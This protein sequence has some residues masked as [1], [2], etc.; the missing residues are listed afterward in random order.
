MKA[1]EPT[2]Y[3]LRFVPAAIA[4]GALAFLLVPARGHAQQALQQV[5]WTAALPLDADGAN[6]LDKL[7]AGAAATRGVAYIDPTAVTFARLEFLRRAPGS[8]TKKAPVATPKLLG[9]PVVVAG[10]VQAT[11]SADASETVPARSTVTVAEAPKLL[12]EAVVV[13]DSV[14][15][16]AP[17]LLGE[18]VGPKLLGEPVVV[19]VSATKG[20]VKASSSSFADM[21]QDH[22]RV[23]LARIEKK[24][25][26]KKT[27]RDQG[28]SYPAAELFLR[29]F[30]RERELEVWVR[31]KDKPTFQMLKKYPICAMAGMLGPKRAEGDGQTP[32]GFYF[33]DGFNPSSDFHLS[34]HLDYPNR[35][36]QILNK[37][38]ALGGNIFIHGGCRTEG[39]L[40]VT[41]DA[42]KE[43]YWLSVEAR[44]VGQKRIPVHIFPARLTDDELFRLTQV[45]DE[46]PDFK[47][48]WA[49]LKPTYDY[50]ETKRELP[51][52]NIDQ[53]G[54]YRIVEPA[55]LANDSVKPLTKRGGSN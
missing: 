27:F 5:L 21:Q 20:A 53:K 8:T 40:A 17:K 9:E 13:P 38:G 46:K 31:E 33:I 30:K 42:I 3:A 51:L 15:A 19:P 48:F 35:S 50:F 2:F 18:P 29:I 47:R 14:A 24:F 25:E 26:L 10:A 45:F 22:D 54:Q 49:N 44:N 28:I 23:L 52:L 7:D 43:L 4:V 34:L 37:G 1:A 36:D 16:A 41:D 39:C 12:G 55:A 32:E 11:A 6:K